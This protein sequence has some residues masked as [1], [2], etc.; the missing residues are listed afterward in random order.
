MP[1]R[2]RLGH[3]EMNYIRA[4]AHTKSP[5]DIGAVL[6][7]TAEVVSRFIRDHVSPPKSV[8]AAQAAEAEKVTIRQELRNS[9]AWKA[10]TEEFFKEELKFFEETYVRLMGQMGREGVLASE[11]TQVFHAVKY[12]VLMSR[13]LR[14]RKVA[15]SDISRLEDIQRDFMSK[16]TSVSDMR[17]RDREYALNLESQVNAA[18][19]SEKALTTEYAKLQERHAD[20]FKLLKTTRDQR[21][22]Q[23]E[24][25]GKNGFLYVIK[26][27]AR[28]DEQ[29]RTGRQIELVKMAGQR[30]Y[31]RLGQLTAYDDGSADNPILSADTVEPEPE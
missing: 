16:F 31:E 12:E 28:R 5:E 20:L 4:N 24:T 23:I 29:E 14:Q 27:L 19:S 10:L 22:K 6:D 3:D 26:E 11:E 21:V 7:R 25:E 18:R 17:D 1:K 15:L 9:E 8:T 13:N 2:G 30:E